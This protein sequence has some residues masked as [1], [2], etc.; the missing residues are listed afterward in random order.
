MKERKK[1][2]FNFAVYET[3]NNVYISICVK[4]LCFKILILWNSQK[5]NFKKWQNR[6]YINTEWNDEIKIIYIYI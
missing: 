6:V 2:I 4:Y 3:I 1:I 5:K